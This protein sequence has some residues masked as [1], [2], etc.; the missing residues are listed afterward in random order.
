[1]ATIQRYVNTASA[2][3]DGTTN[4]TAGATAA[5]ASLSA[6]IAAISP[7]A[8]DDVIIDC[9]GTAADTTSV[10]VNFA[11]APASII[12]RGN[13][14][15]AAGFY[16][17]ASLI[18][19]S[20]YRLAPVGAVNVLTISENNTTVDGIQIIASG[21]ANRA[22]VIAGSLCTIRKCR[23]RANTCDYGIGQATDWVITGTYTFENNL[24]VGFNVDQLGIR[25]T[26]HANP[27]MNIYHNT[28]Y[29]DGS[30]TGIRLVQANGA[31]TPTF[32]I[33]GNASA[34]SG[35]GNDYDASAMLED[36]ATVNLADN[37]FSEAAG[38]SGEIV[39][40]TTTDAWTSPGTGESADFTVKN[41]SSSLYSAV[42]PTLL[43]SD[44]TDATRDGANHDVGAFE[45]EITGDEQN[46][47][48]GS[49]L[50]GAQTSPGN[51]HSVAL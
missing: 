42:N 33:K 17:G 7:T 29:G 5:F 47:I 10:T 24:I 21:G 3:G 31:G 35:T 2:G 14:S 36:G 6:A 30:S 9:C 15:D 1:M 18:S 12:I 27:T 40:G 28:L 11:T 43:T 46:A 45:L 51:T 16:D 8:A 39:L 25:V 20:H 48:T 23:M 32:N 37:A 22:A 34:N 50:T 49:S 38:T 26:G 19:T 41:T 4:G 44:I 13:R